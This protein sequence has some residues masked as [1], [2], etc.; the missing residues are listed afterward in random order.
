MS[1]DTALL[2]VATPWS[3]LNFW[4]VVKF[5]VAL[6]VA[7]AVC[8]SFVSTYNWFPSASITLPVLS[9]LKVLSPIWTSTVPVAG[10]LINAF[11]SSTVEPIVY[12]LPP[13][14]TLSPVLIASI[15]K[16]AVPSPLFVRVPFNPA[17]CASRLIVFVPLSPFNK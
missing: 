15:V 13:I 16:V 2:S 8:P 17:S 9:I 4:V 6:N 10:A 11:A 7:A 5:E 3:L 1:T 14:A 12:V